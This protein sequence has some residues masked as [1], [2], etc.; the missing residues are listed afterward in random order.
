MA[1]AVTQSRGRAAVSGTFAG[2]LSLVWYAARDFP[3]SLCTSPG[4]LAAV[5]NRRLRR[6]VSA[7][8][9]SAP[10]GFHVK[11]G[12]RRKR[13]L[14]RCVGR[15]QS[16][17]GSWRACPRSSQ[18]RR[19]APGPMGCGAAHHRACPGGRQTERTCPEPFARLRVW[20]SPSASRGFGPSENRQ[21]GGFRGDR[22]GSPGLVPQFPSDRGSPANRGE[23]TA[24]ACADSRQDTCARLM[25]GLDL[26]RD[27]APRN[28]SA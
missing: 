19:P 26:R 11:R 8:R 7:A 4:H 25:L 28:G 2:R 24:T 6:V 9:H 3:C 23:R 1:R 5:L 13:E 20:T 14:D 27:R 12:A 18:G 16:A 10:L 21:I 17:E 15:A 22:R